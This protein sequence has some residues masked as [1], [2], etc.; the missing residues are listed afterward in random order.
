M[1]EQHYIYKIVRDEDPE[2][3]RDWDNIGTMCCWH[4]RYNLGDVQPQVEAQDYVA[5]LIGW[6]DEK[7]EAVY[8]Y[9]FGKGSGTN[10]E[11]HD[12]AHSKLSERIQEEFDRQY[13]SLPLYIYDHSGISIST[14][15]FSCPWDSGQLGLI[16]VSKDKIRQ[17]YGIKHVTKAWADKIR[18]YLD[19]EV[20]VYDQYLTGDVWGFQ[21]FEVPEGVNPEELSEE[22]IEDL[23]EVDSLWGLYGEE[24]AEQEAKESAAYFE[25]HHA[26]LMFKRKQAEFREAGQLEL[27]LAA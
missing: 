3:P 18:G 11:L 21:V 15:S 7:Q 22:E 26:E 4:R 20:Q 19:Q 25:E 14:G 17:D 27:A 2:S 23:E 10:E 13:I 5:E 6:D 16:Y 8:D 24:Y 9:W 1:S 12:Y